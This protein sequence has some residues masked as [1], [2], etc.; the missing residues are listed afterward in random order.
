MVENDNCIYYLYSKNYYLSET[1]W[2][3]EIYG[4]TSYIFMLFFS[5][6]AFVLVCICVSGC[7]QCS[8]KVFRFLGAEVTESCQPTDM[9][10]GNKLLTCERAAEYLN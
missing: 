3:T 4:N 5:Y 7:P 1:A 6:C 2:T 9:G 10:A 8:K